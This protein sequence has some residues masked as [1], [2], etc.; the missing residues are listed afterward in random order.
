MLRLSFLTCIAGAFECPPESCAALA[1]VALLQTTVQVSPAL[2]PHARYANKSSLPPHARLADIS[3]SL[4]PNETKAKQE[5]Q[6]Q[7]EKVTIPWLD[8]GDSVASLVQQRGHAAR[9]NMSRGIPIA[10]VMQ[11]S[12][13]C[14]VILLVS[15]LGQFRALF[16]R[17]FSTTREPIEAS[18]AGRQTSVT[19]PALIII[20]AVIYLS[21]STAL[22]K[23]NKY[24]MADGRFPFTVNLTLGHTAAGFSFLFTLRN[25]KPSFFPSL[26]DPEKRHSFGVDYLVKNVGPIAVCFSASLVLSN[27]AYI[28]CSVTFLQLMKEANVMIVYALSLA[29]GSEIFHNARARVLLCILFSTS[30]AVEG[31]LAFSLKGFLIQGG[32]QLFECSKVVLQAALLCAPTAQKIDPLSFSLFLQLSCFVVLGIVLV[33]TMTVMPFT[34]TATSA[35]YAAWWPHLVL[36]ACVA[37]GLNSSIAF[38]VSN[39]SGVAAILLGILK[40]ILVVLIDVVFSGTPVST[41]QVIAFALQSGLVCT[42]SLF[43][44]FPEQS[45]DIRS[46]ISDKA[47]MDKASKDTR[48]AN[49]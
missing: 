49:S 2:P 23:Y 48:K 1:G 5:G 30:M 42:Y 21:F 12:V 24:L 36:N 15:L 37:L 32:S 20:Q 47:G 17:L 33:L 40:D 43:K 26:E 31:E 27:M 6:M 44:M 45:E 28:Y 22:I 25:I 34:E 10:R 4:L 19:R 8:S 3:L 9:K 39:T 29:W 46:P 7:D 11:F 18:A 13:L 16:R 41:V 38:F 14:L 35:D